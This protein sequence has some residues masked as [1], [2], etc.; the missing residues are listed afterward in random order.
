MKEFIGKRRKKLLKGQ[1]KTSL[2]ICLTSKT[3]TRSI[4][5]PLDIIT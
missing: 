2:P 1:P 5:E 4:K 3:S